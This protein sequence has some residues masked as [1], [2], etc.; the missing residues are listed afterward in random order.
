[1]PTSPRLVTDPNYQMSNEEL[2]GYN[3]ACVFWYEN[4]RAELYPPSQVG[5]SSRYVENTQEH[6]DAYK[7][8]LAFL[9]ADY[10]PSNTPQAGE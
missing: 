7:R 9:G 6:E 5:N 8:A 3:M 10:E 1:M 4:F 2:E